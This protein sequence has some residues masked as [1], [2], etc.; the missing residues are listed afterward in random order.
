MKKSLAAVF[1][2]LLFFAAQRTEVLAEPSCMPYSPL[3]SVYYQT[4]SDGKKQM[5]DAVYDAL[6]NGS[7]GV[8]VP[9]VCTRNEAKVMLDQMFNECPELCAFHPD[10]V[11][12]DTGSSQ[13]VKYIHLSYKRSIAEQQA[14][15]LKVSRIAADFSDF[16]DVLQ[17][18]C[19]SMTYDYTSTDT[20][21][22]FA[23]E[24]MQ[25]GKG[26]CNAYA[27]LVVMLCHFAGIE[28]SYIDG[29]AGGAG[30][31]W[32]IV[33]HAGQYTLV[34]VTWADINPGKCNYDWIG[35]STQEMGIDHKPYGDR[36]V[37][38]LCVNTQAT[39]LSSAPEDDIMNFDRIAFMARSGDSGDNVRAIQTRLI[40]LGYLSGRADGI[41]GGKTKAAVATFQERNGIHGVE[42]SSGVASALTQAA[43]FSGRAVPNGGAKRL[44]FWTW[45]GDR[46]PFSVYLADI[47][48][49]G[50]D[51]TMQF[52]IR[53]DHPELA[54]KALTVRYWADGADGSL[55][56]PM[57]EYYVWGLNL[58]PGQSGFVRVS[59]P[60]DAGLRKAALVKWNVI[61]VQFSNG[62]I[63]IN[64]NLSGLT[65]Y[66]IR[67]INQSVTPR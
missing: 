46:Y 28:C 53:N 51:G 25:R 45:T 4:L 36:Y 18:V 40:Q 33:G 26:V 8:A 24:G 9:E 32:N 38:P 56:Y 44:P 63:F 41:F 61:E 35:L 27:Q 50:T 60:P 14:F 19:G 54:I 21:R 29:R 64:E 52:T 2:C 67:T 15:I 13:R 47:S 10:N 42:G 66:Y 34:D 39:L 58:L 43:L 62:E 49:V 23:Y 11:V 48:I 1:V 57:R 65:G 37:I 55:V 22:M 6:Y 59:M 20:G 17:Y 31:A 5:F 16:N 7:S 30:H 12:Y 3:F